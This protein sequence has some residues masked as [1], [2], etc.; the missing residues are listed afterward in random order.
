[1]ALSRSGAATPRGDDEDLRSFAI[2]PGQRS[3]GKKIAQVAWLGMKFEAGGSQQGLNISQTRMDASLVN[4]HANLTH[5]V[6]ARGGFGQHLDLRTFDVELQQIDVP[7]HVRRQP[8]G[9]DVDD[10]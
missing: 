5:T 7:V 8:F 4:F 9:C 1:M 3:R 6:K 10:R 2:E